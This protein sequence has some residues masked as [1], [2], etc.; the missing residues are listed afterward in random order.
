[1]NKDIPISDILTQIRDSIFIIF[2]NINL[3]YLSIISLVLFSLIPI[4]Y[5]LLTNYVFKNHNTKYI[6]N[7]ISHFNIFVLLLIAFIVLI[8]IILGTL[9]FYFIQASIVKSMLNIEYWQEIYPIKSFILNG[10]RVAVSYFVYEIVFYIITTFLFIVYI[11]IVV[12]IS[13]IPYIA[14]LIFLLALVILTIFLLYLISVNMIG[15]IFVCDQDMDIIDAMRRSFV[16]VYNNISMFLKITGIFLIYLL[17]FIVLINSINN[18]TISV[19]L[20]YSHIGVAIFIILII[21]D[22]ILMTLLYSF[23]N[24]FILTFWTGIYIKLKTLNISML[25]KTIG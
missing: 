15:V 24:V 23:L 1:M 13:F 7:L 18:M 12:A 10:R 2:K 25:T 20:Y 19:I 17:F 3:L 16:I 11:L 21:M 9:I 6:L 5:F 8:Y 22:F 4:L 14:S